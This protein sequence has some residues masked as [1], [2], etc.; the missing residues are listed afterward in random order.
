VGRA[1]CVKFVA[2]SALANT[3]VTGF[4]TQSNGTGPSNRNVKL[5]KASTHFCF[6]NDVGMGTTQWNDSA[7]ITFSSTDGYYYL[8]GSWSGGN[9]RIFARATCVAYNQL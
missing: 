2:S 9:A 5:A 1:S 4:W 6:L 8:T 7:Y 3:T